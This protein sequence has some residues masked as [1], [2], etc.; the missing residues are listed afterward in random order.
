M[1][2]AIPAPTGEHTVNNVKYEVISSFKPC[3]DGKEPEDLADKV[4]RLI[5]TEDIRPRKK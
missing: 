5:M 3:E 4:K 1:K 2:K